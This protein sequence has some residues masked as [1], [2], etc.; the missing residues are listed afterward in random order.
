MRVKSF[1]AESTAGVSQNNFKYFVNDRI[2][3]LCVFSIS[4]ISLFIKQIGNI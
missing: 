4:F 2:Y 3:G 1:N